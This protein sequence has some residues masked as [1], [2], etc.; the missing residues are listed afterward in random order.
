MKRAYLRLDPDFFMRKVVEDGYPPAMAMALVAAFCLAESQPERGRFAS[1][2]LL[3]LLLEEPKDGTRTGLGRW[4]AKLIDK[5]DLVKTDDGTVY[6]DGWDEWQEGDVTV[7]ERMSRVRGRRK[8]GTPSTVTNDT[9]RTVTTTVTTP[10]LVD[11]SKR[12]SGSGSRSASSARVTFDHQREGL[13]SLTPEAERAILDAGG[14]HVSTLSDAMLGHLDGLVERNG[15]DA[16][17]SEMAAVRERGART[18]QQLVFRAR[19]RLEPLREEPP[20]EAD[21]ADALRR[22]WV[23]A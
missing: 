5:G 10:S 12:D 7:R 13:P 2:R 23:G 6:V 14:F 3:R 17:C 19:D 20:S 11:N 21:E 8:Q 4:V 16:V 1:E 22:E 15:I 9:P 18:P